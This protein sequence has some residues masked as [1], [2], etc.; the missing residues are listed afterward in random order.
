[1]GSWL[2]C[3]LSSKPIFYPLELMEYQSKSQGWKLHSVLLKF[4]KG[5]MSIVYVDR[6]CIVLKVQ[7]NLHW[8]PPLNKNADFC[9]WGLQKILYF[10]YISGTLWNA[11]LI[12]ECI[13]AIFPQRIQSFFPLKNVLIDHLSLEYNIYLFY[14]FVHLE[15]KL[16]QVKT[17]AI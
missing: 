4:K 12:D 14:N 5:S 11:W 1:M 8:R 6:W 7:M 17:K 3:D 10:F 2:Q 9:I 16:Q 13:F 15:Y